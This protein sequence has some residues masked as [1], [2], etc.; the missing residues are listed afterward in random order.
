MRSNTDVSVAG[1]SDTQRKRSRAPAGPAGPPLPTGNSFQTSSLPPTPRKLIAT[2]SQRRRPQPS[3][4]TSNRNQNENEN[5][6][7]NEGSSG[8]SDEEDN[9]SNN[10]IH[11]S[12]SI[13]RSLTGD[14]HMTSQAKDFGWVTSLAELLADFSHHSSEA[15]RQVSKLNKLSS[16]NTTE[17]QSDDFT[18]E[19]D[20]VAAYDENYGWGVR[21][22]HVA[23]AAAE[24]NH[25]R[26]GRDQQDDHLVDFVS[27]CDR[28][29]QAM[30][31]AF[32]GLFVGVPF[33]AA[34]I[35][36]VL[37]RTYFPADTD[38]LFYSDSTWI[39]VAT[40]VLFGVVALLM[41]L[42]Y[43]CLFAFWVRNEQ[44][45]QLLWFV[46]VVFV[47]LPTSMLLPLL[48]GHLTHDDHVRRVWTG[49]LCLSILMGVAIDGWILILHV[50]ALSMRSLS[51]KIVETVLCLVCVSFST[52]LLFM[53]V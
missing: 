42:P 39:A 21:R 16:R 24:E 30:A 40:P 8:S 20:T 48:T 44:T 7:E 52:F 29:C 6:N 46:H 26:R 4:L 25:Q 10:V 49:V 36:L 3:L 2:S 38:H 27:V 50:S 22:H 32:C 45:R 33:L 19:N 5:E 12:S 31:G 11:R 43:S 1:A 37:R 51:L 34:V 41:A 15:Q 14:V 47:A 28:R 23:T 13:T 17:D 53:C 18:W 9:P 35:M